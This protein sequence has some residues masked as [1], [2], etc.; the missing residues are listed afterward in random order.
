MGTSAKVIEPPSA[1]TT[2]TS[3]NFASIALDASKDVLVEFYAPWCGHCKKLAPVYDSVAS[4]FINEENVVVAKVDATEN[5][6][7]GETYD[8]SG[9]PTIKFFPRGEG[10]EVVDYKEARTANAFVQFL[11]ENAG[12]RRNADGTLSRSAGR[13]PDLD[14][15]AK[16]ILTESASRTEVMG[17]LEAECES[18]ARASECKY[19][20]KYAKKVG[21]KGEDYVEKERDRLS[22]LSRSDSITKEKRDN[23]ILRMNVLNGFLEGEESVEDAEDAKQEL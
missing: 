7:L 6:D 4:A 19:Y 15:L 22:K 17:E 23:F 14:R 21:E 8:V 18:V 12:T 3:A 11:N 5:S 2:I 10:E 9:Y 16:R 20:L 1:V 13:F